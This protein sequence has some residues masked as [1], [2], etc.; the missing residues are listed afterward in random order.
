[1]IQ[2]FT[3]KRET[4]NPDRTSIQHTKGGGNA[5]ETPSGV[6]SRTAVELRG[7]P[8]GTGPCAFVRLVSRG[9]LVDRLFSVS[10]G[11]TAQ[12]ASSI[13]LHKGATQ[14]SLRRR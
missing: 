10:S 4:S 3:W 2:P 9:L 12:R 7:A 14:S 1:M 13:T 8:W 11:Y 6:K 5:A